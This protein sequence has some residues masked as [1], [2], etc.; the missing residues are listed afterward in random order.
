M[1]NIWKIVLGLIGAFLIALVCFYG[2]GHGK[3]AIGDLQSRAKAAL[4]ANGLGDT[5]VTFESNPLRR[6]AHLSGNLTADQR[7]KALAVVNGISGVY[8]VEWD[9]RAPAPAKDVEAAI[10]PVVP[11][12]QVANCQADLNGLISGKT[13]QFATGSATIAPESTDLI[14]AVAKAA[15]ICSGVKILVEGHTD[16]TGNAAANQRLSEARA[17]SVRDALTAKGVPAEKLD[18]KGFGSSKPL[19]PAATPEANARNRRIEFSVTSA[20]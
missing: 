7:A 9:G 18:A 6:V 11:A 20:G 10:P 8:M 2:L 19:D 15:T 14:A 12:T 4:A 17:S 13:V 3:Q 5:N 16:T 1:S